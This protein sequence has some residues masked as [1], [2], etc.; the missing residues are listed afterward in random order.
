MD[1]DY[2]AVNFTIAP[3]SEEAA[4]VLSAM[5]GEVGFD[6]FEATDAGLKAYIPA[7]RFCED[8]V[9]AVIGDFFIPGLHII[10]NI[11]DMESRDWNTAWE[12]ESFD[13][14]LER[15]FGIRLHPRGA[16]GSGS[17]ETTYQLVSLLCGLDFTG[18]RVLDMGC[19]TGVLG[20]AMSK[21]GAAHVVAIDIDDLSVA[22]AAQNFALN[23]QFPHEVVH[24][25]ASAIAGMFDTVVANIHK[26]IILHDLPVYAAHMNRGGLLITSG[27]FTEDVAD[28]AAAAQRL[29]LKQIDQRDL[30][31]WAVLS[32]R[33][34]E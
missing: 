3:M 9:R 10:Y 24:G 1:M 22:N 4:D 7:D 15:E 29:D 12:Q 20:I 34:S 13:P 32:F 11:S 31:R 19:G 18:Q 23:G 8:D 6:T 30:N 21:R 5:L 16:F 17:H 14:V 27:F 2:K 33:L 25:D 28:I 26:N